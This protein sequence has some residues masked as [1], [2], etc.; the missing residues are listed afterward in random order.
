[1][2]TEIS[3]VAEEKKPAAKRKPAKKRKPAADATA[4]PNRG[5]RPKGFSPKRKAVTSA[6]SIEAT[7]ASLNEAANYLGLLDASKVKGVMIRIN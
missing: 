6:G 7:F 2:K 1:M 5:G 4:K 3:A